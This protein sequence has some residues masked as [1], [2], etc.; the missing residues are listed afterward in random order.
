MEA[1]FA[2][3]A[4]AT[5]KMFAARSVPDVLRVL[6]DEAR[7]LLGAGRAAAT[8]AG[9]DRLRYEAPAGTREG[10][11]TRAADSQGGDPIAAPIAVNGDARLGEIEVSG[12]AAG[13]FTEADAALLAEL[14]RQAAL[15]I[16]TVRRIEAALRQAEET[17]RAKE[18]RFRHFAALGSDW[19]W[20]TDAE[21]RIVFMDGPP[22]VAAGFA[23]G[24]R[25]WEY[26][27]VD[28][29][30]AEWRRHRRALALR[31]P[32][33]NFEY[34]VTDTEGRLRRFSVNGDPIFDSQGSFV[35]YRGTTT[36]I[37]A[38]RDAE[39]ASRESE[40]RFRDFAEIASDWLWESDEH[41]C[42]VTLTGSPAPIAREPIGFTRWE[43]CGQSADHP[44]WRQH[45]ADL[46]A[47]RPFRDFAFTLRDAEGREHYLVA[48]GRPRFSADGKFLGYR[49]TTT[50][51]TAQR[52]AEA[53]AAET[54]RKYR[55]IVETANEGIWML[56]AERRT[57][58]AN[59]R[60]CQMLGYEFS[61]LEGRPHWDFLEPDQRE[62]AL[63]ILK[64][65]G[66]RAVE[67]REYRY[68]RKDGSTIWML[69][70][71]NPIVDENGATLGVLGMLVDITERKKAEEQAVRAKREVDGILASIS[72]GFIALDN[73]WRFTYM[74]AAAERIIGRPAIGIIGLTA[75]EVIKGH[76]DNVFAH[77]YAQAKRDGE[78]VALTAWSETMGIW[79][80]VRAYP[81]SEGITIFFRDVGAEREAHLALAE[82]GRRLEAALEEKESVLASI[83]EAFV[84]L[85]NE[86]RFTF[87]NAAA[88]RL[89]GVPASDLMGCASTIAAFDPSN[90]FHVCCVESK[91]SAEPIAFTFFSTYFDRWLE[92][93]GYPHPAGY[94]IFF[95]DV[96]EERRAHRE[97][98]ASRRR[99]EA[100]REI[101]E[102]LFET[103]LDLICITDSYGNFVQVNPGTSQQFGYPLA[104]MIGRNA[105][106]YIHAEDID[107]TRAAL[108][109]ARLSLKPQNFENRCR[110]SDGSY[111]S[112][113]WSTVWSPA[114]R[115][116]FLIGRDMTER[117]EAQEQLNRAQRLQAI[118]QLTGG[119][120]HDFNN[121]LTVIMGNSDILAETL[122]SSPNLRRHADL[123]VAAARRAAELTKQLLAFARRQALAP[124]A[125]DPNRLVGGLREL[126]VRTLAAEMEIDLALDPST[127]RCKVDATQLETAILNLAVNARDA[128]SAGGHLRIATF[129]RTIAAG[130][131]G[132]L[133]P[134]DYAVIEVADTGTGMS[135][136]VLRRVFEPFFTTKDIGKGSGLGLAMVYGFVKQSGGHVTVESTVG[137]GTTFRLF[138]PRLDE[139]VA[140]EP[141]VRQS[142]STFLPR[143]TERILVVEDDAAVREL[144]L[145]QLRVLGYRVT[146]AEN[147]LG[148]RTILEGD[149]AFDLLFTDV[150][151][152]GGM[153]GMQLAEEAAALRP[154]LKVLFTT[155]HAAAP[156]ATA[157]GEIGP[158]RLLQ[159]PYK[160]ADLAAAIRG[161]LDRGA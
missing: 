141:G 146:A 92:I 68:R 155:G 121:L 71:S 33:R 122:K 94:T 95:R 13:A 20:E 131:S 62:Q 151:M 139:Q 21:H 1:R 39:E 80:E 154:G 81:H 34:D 60:L 38:R 120:A 157:V 44:A 88:E 30:R 11:S 63:A 111:V 98:L 161:A 69:V 148:A 149:S 82:S 142:A 150:L 124:A 118:G 55:Q 49:G 25:R 128:M 160:I 59:P 37:T 77:C 17:A 9:G 109:A 102:R 117:I 3:L 42:L 144:V 57:T 26:G 116:Y 31:E 108:R 14:A 45:I 86:W 89:W 72:D 66:L 40:T 51:R 24:K 119:I 35:G 18:D 87:V 130:A 27:D 58:Y 158:S 123:N 70:T 140:E 2:A 156:T 29:E 78:S 125:I 106:E 91:R 75:S 84:A 99:L 136:E 138:L 90:P 10:G 76:D 135:P 105:N 28:C 52:D 19:L 100:A 129:N 153:N 12:K 115:K 64:T 73:E 137:Q 97:L 104:E 79:M 107:A 23:P 147:G 112:V 133:T 7:A 4:Q 43:L 65:R 54:E 103:S 56:D 126:L 46:E 145:N 15:A 96:S 134:G 22:T 47:R 152:P 101:N 50:D 127:W 114:E 159:K 61:E 41:H 83:S 53:A 93:R 36:D 48:N 6:A 132:E 67:R 143:G 85:D 113:N 110:R 16:E 32:F 74:N 8:L 5:A